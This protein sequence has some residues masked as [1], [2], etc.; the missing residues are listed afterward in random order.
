[1]LS[2][3]SDQTL[4]DGGVLP[5]HEPAPPEAAAKGAVVLPSKGSADGDVSVAMA[6]ATVEEA[7][8]L[9]CNTA[10]YILM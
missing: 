5:H 4:G 1:M 2:A 3:L 6:A 9:E 8:A 7:F 10:Y